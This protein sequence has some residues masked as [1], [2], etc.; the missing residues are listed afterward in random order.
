MADTEVSPPV[1]NV[2]NPMS[3]ADPVGAEETGEALIAKVTNFIRSSWARRKMVSGILIFGVI[4]TAVFA[5]IQ[6]NI[7][8]STTTLMPPDNNSTYSGIMSALTASGPAASLGSQALGLSTPGELYVSILK[9]RSV[10][11]PLITRFDLAHYYDVHYRE[12]AR[13]LL[14]SDTAVVQD[15][16]SGVI[17]ISVSSTNASLASNIAQ[18]YVSELNRVVTD[19]STSAARR[20]RIFLEGRLKEVKQ[21][22]DQSSQA[23]SQF[24]TKS[25]AM[26]VS[27]Q[28]KAMLDAGLKLQAEL[29][30]ARSR[31]AGLKQV[32]SDDNARVRAAKARADELQHQIDTIVGMHKGPNSSSDA[33]NSTYPSV[34]Q[35]PSLGVTYYDLERKVR[36]DE[37]VWENLT[38][39]YEMA[40]VQ[41]A[42]QIPSLHVLDTADVPERK[43]GPKRRSMLIVG[44]LLSLLIAL[45]SVATLNIWDQMD[46]EAEPKKLLLEAGGAALDPRLWIWRLPVLSR[47]NRRFR[48]A[49]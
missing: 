42:Q 26:D 28:A 4:L 13:R 44:T 9:S 47:I 46:S 25:G 15:R 8:T 30:D 23:L 24:S 35:L 3:L 14:L 36:V 16:K 49:S 31:L 37:A 11:D 20:E 1:S 10:L 17:S 12:D 7:Y 33:S 45:V 19:N 38:K 5:F 22:L 39:Q 21:Q 43:S 34:D 29:V 2:Q 41:E 48:R 40:K 6:P 32:Y 18:A 27:S